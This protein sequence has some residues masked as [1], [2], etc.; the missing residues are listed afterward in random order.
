MSVTFT[1]TG[2]RV[3]RSSGLVSGD[4]TYYCRFRIDS[5]SPYIWYWAESSNYK[6]YLQSS[7]GYVWCEGSGYKILWSSEYLDWAEVVAVVDLAS[8]NVTCYARQCGSNTEMPWTEFTPFANGIQGGSGGTLY[9]GSYTS[10]SGGCT[11][12]DFK[13]WNRQLP[14]SEIKQGLYGSPNSGLRSG[15]AV[16]LP[17]QSV[18]G[19]A[20]DLSDNPGLSGDFTFV[21]TPTTGRESPGRIWTPRWAPL[22]LGASAGSAGD[23]GVAITPTAVGAAYGAG[24]GAVSVATA[25]AG[26]GSSGIATAAG[27]VSV[28]VAPAAVGASIAAAAGAVPVGVTV[29]AVG[30]TSADITIS[31]RYAINSDV[32]Q[33]AHYAAKVGFCDNSSAGSGQIVWIAASGADPNSVVNMYVSTGGAEPSVVA[34]YTPTG[35]RVEQV[36][37]ACQGSNGDVHLIVNATSYGDILYRRFTLTHSGGA[38]TGGTEAAS[39]DAAIGTYTTGRRYSMIE[40]VAQDNSRHIVYTMSADGGGTLWQVYACKFPISATSA[41]A[42]VGLDGTGS[43]TAVFS[44]SSETGWE[45]TAAVAQFADKT[46]L[47]GGGYCPVEFPNTGDYLRKSLCATSGNTTWSVGTFTA[48]TIGEYCHGT[49]TAAGSHVYRARVGTGNYVRIDKIDSDGTVTEN[50]FPAF[51]ID[52]TAAV[53]CV[54]VSADENVAFVG[55]AS[56]YD[57]C[58]IGYCVGGEWT[59]TE[60]EWV[61]YGSSCSTWPNGLAFACTGYTQDYIAYVTAELASTASGDGSV[62]IGISPAATSASTAASVGAC[63]IA[64]AATGVGVALKPAA[65]SVAIAVAASA[66][67]Q[68]VRGGAGAAAVNIAPAATGTARA[69]SVGSV[70][71]AISPAAAGT[72]LAP[73]AGSAPVNVAPVAVGA[74]RLAASGSTAINVAPTSVGL[75]IGAGSGAVNV[76]ASA[77]AVGQSLSSGSG[78]GAVSV[79]LA[80]SGAGGS[81]S[82]SVGALDASVAVSAQGSVVTAGAG[83]IPVSVTVSGTGTGL[84]PAGGA[85]SA[86]VTCAAVGEAYLAGS[87]GAVAVGVTAAG[88]SASVAAASGTIAVAV[89]AVGR[90]EIVV[91]PADPTVTWSAGARPNVT[92]WAVP[93]ARPYVVTWSSELTWPLA[94]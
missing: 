83:A 67:G 51:Q 89:A 34:L 12:A 80:V 91:P 87:S 6:L 18:D 14:A 1:G 23:I 30:G 11:I 60:Y 69:A 44:T 79:G 36:L 55:T 76:D 29:A 70:A 37:A 88:T 85:C 17:M 46:L 41:S 25:V 35:G 38:I 75:V 81:T 63:A 68:T 5:T 19:A 52:T 59:L 92:A 21:G 72:G 9:V 10:G 49:L 42:K 47:I 54:S 65:S 78:V 28:A 13:L 31:S 82:A 3:I 16:W 86:G 22:A 8:T 74:A 58:H 84:V 64:V 40:A 61:N 27:A 45:R 94:A 39:F 48:E 32:G 77:A 93:T 57:L 15:L 62:A 2:Q 50:A 56:Y 90:S 24:V 26:V 20:K 71:V 66:A 73:A 53:V 43:S 33:Y 7:G 4:R